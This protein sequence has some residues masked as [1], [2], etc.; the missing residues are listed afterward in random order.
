MESSL[1][2]YVGLSNKIDIELP[3][4]FSGL[5][6]DALPDISIDVFSKIVQQDDLDIVEYWSKIEN[7]TILK[8]RTLFINA[9][10]KCHKI[11]K[12]DICECILE[13]N[14]E[15]FGTALW[16]LLGA[17][18][19]FE[20]ISTSR[21]NRYTTIDKSKAKELRDAY[22]DVFTDELQAAVNSLD[23]NDNDCNEEIIEESNIVS[24]AYVIP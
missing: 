4:V 18:F 15:L 12:I 9:V 11:N 23:V 21:L 10:N 20:R 19:M 7:R 17:E 8:F 1:Y 13:S 14:F 5:Y 6:V 16:Y 24:T 3:E 22:L 2:G